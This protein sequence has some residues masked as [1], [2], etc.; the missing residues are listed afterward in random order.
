MRYSNHDGKQPIIIFG[1][2]GS[3]KVPD[4]NTFDGV[5]TIRTDKDEDWREVPHAFQTG[6]GRAVGLA[7][8]AHAI[9]AGRN[10]RCDGQ[11]ALAVLDLMEGFLDS[12]RQG[13]AFVPSASY[14]RPAPMP[15]GLPFGTLD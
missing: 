15:T 5:V 6:Y 2:E 4:P 13:K 9:R 14:E 8:M 12:S 1:T 3:L 10:F 11:Q 7:D